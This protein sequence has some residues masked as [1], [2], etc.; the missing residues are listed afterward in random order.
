M[1]SAR[2]T[3][4]ILAKAVFRRKLVAARVG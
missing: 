3:C 2:N 1:T 4:R